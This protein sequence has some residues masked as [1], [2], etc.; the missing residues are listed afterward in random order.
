[1]GL[2]APQAM[3]PAPMPPGAAQPSASP[4]AP[5]PGVAPGQS[6]AGQGRGYNGPLK[7]HGITTQVRNGVTEWEGKKFFVSADG[8][9]VWDEQN[10]V[11]GSID[12]EGNFI[13]TSPEHQKMLIDAG[14]AQPGG[15]AGG[16]GQP[17][18]APGAAPR[19]GLR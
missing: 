5:A 8:K 11:L 14:I 9:V 15:G 17:G 6:G 2:S 3:P 7:Y 13:P 4:L 1:M 19:G 16:E 18:L 12:Q 10:R